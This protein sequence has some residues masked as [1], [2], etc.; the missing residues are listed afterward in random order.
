MPVP[1]AE[2]LALVADAGRPALDF[3]YAV[4]DRAAADAPALDGLLADLAGAFRA[5]GAGVAAL[6]GGSPLATF[7]AAGSPEAA[8]RRP[9]QET[10]DL[11]TKARE[12][13]TALTVARPQGGS[14]LVAAFGATDGPGWLLWLE[15]GRRPAWTAG[16]AAALS[17]AGRAL[18]RWLVPGE[19]RPRWAEQLERAARQQR[20]EAVAQVTR[21]LAHDFGNVLTGILGFSELALA[22]PMPA[23]SPLHS[24]LT[25]V[26]RGAQGGAQLTQQLRLFSR[27]QAHA[28]RPCQPAAVLA[29][30]ETRLRGAAGAA[31]Q[32]QTTL[33]G[34]LPPVALD[35][36][37][38][39][40]VL[41]PVLDNALEA[42]TAP[43]LPADPPPQVTVSARVAVLGPAECRDFYGDLRPGPH[44]EIVVADTGP[45][46]SPEALQRLFAE[47]FFSTKSRRRGF[48]LATAYG[49]L[50]A[51]HG[52]LD[53]RPGRGRGVEARL[54]VPTAAAP[55]PAAV[56]PSAGEVVRG[57]KVLVVDDDPMILQ[58]VSR[59]LERAGYR[60]KAVASAEAALESYAAATGDPFRV[61]LSDVLMPDVGGVDLAHRLLNRDP[62]VRVVF[63]SGQVSMDFVQQTFRGSCFEVLPKPFRPEGLLRAVRSALDRTLVAG[64]RAAGGP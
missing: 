61:V 21:R 33:P 29:E 36:D 57:D 16:E 52:G 5:P 22:Q 18:R 6:L 26:H 28:S 13:P 62:G 37:Q 1:Q 51:H 14:F 10:P 45:G 55:A 3:V 50:C 8:D 4:L 23:H 20:L 30:E 40:Q 2:S 63:M 58:F 24:Y 25:E 47:P 56:A 60:V 38:L 44:V 53:L 35:A 41:A 64:G 15:D 39:R 19:S 12:A 17:L 9:W 49:I 27:R 32:V 11:V 54:V 42:V 34:D 43:G 7:P 46:L 59:T 48:G 31:V